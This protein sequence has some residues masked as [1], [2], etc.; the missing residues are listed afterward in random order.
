MKKEYNAPYAEKINF[1]YKD[2]VVASNAINPAS[3]CWYEAKTSY[4][5]FGCHNTEVGAMN[6]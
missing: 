4:A 6:N 3:S 1:N 2:Q 5:F